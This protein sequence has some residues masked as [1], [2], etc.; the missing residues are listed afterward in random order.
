MGKKPTGEDSISEQMTSASKSKGRRQG[1]G[2]LR[3]G[4]SLAAR[5]RDSGQEPR[6]LVEKHS[7][8]LAGGVGEICY[9]LALHVPSRM[10]PVSPLDQMQSEAGEIGRLPDA[11]DIG[12]PRWREAESGPGKTDG[13]RRAQVA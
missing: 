4:E 12:Q 3:P 10:L 5:E 9:Q 2:K 8:R 13:E 11:V 7:H 6:P 1:P